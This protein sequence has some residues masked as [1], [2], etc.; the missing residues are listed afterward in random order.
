[1]IQLSDFCKEEKEAGEGK[2][3]PCP[4]AQCFSTTLHRTLTTSQDAEPAPVNWKVTSVEESHFLYQEAEMGQW[5]PN[6]AAV[7]T[8]PV[9]TAPL[10][11]SSAQAGRAYVGAAVHPHLWSAPPEEASGAPKLVERPG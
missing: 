7:R 4:L 6:L 11:A 9:S 3:G 5:R 2:L 10:W 8:I 1:M